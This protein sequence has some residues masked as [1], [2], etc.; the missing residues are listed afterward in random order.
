MDINFSEE[1]IFDVVIIG[2]GPSGSTAAYYLATA[3]LKVL[4]V[5]KEKFPRYKTCGGGV[6][7]R[8]AGYLD[9]GLSNVIEKCINSA[10]VYENANNQ[11]FTVKKDFPII[12][13]VMREKFD[14]YLVKEAVKKNARFISGVEVINLIEKNNVVEIQA[15]G[16]TVK[17]KFVICADGA[18]GI[19]SRIIKKNKKLKKIPALEWE[20][21]VSD[22]LYNKFSDYA[23]FDF[24]FIDEGYVWIFPKKYHLSVGVAAVGKID[25]KLSAVLEKYLSEIGIT[26]I[27]HI[28]KH[29]YII[30]L[31]SSIKKIVNNRIL[32][33]GDALG[34]ADPIV[35]EGISYAIL[36][37]KLAA[38]AII[39]GKL[40]PK[41]VIKIY[42][43]NLAKKI[44]RELKFAEFCSI[45]VYRYPSIR[46]LLF[47]KYGDKLVNFMTGII[48]ENAKYSSLFL[49]PLSYLKLIRY[50]FRSVQRSEEN[51]REVNSDV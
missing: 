1:Q 48:T 31:S 22:D 46:K 25:F 7:S 38:D 26:G 9:F 40:E 32:L 35:F 39:T 23:R 15:N 33:V 44:F 24:G 11:K 49:N 14:D 10:V 30:P 20:I 3:G 12:N 6:V 21:R 29:G 19:S 8:A 5:E 27:N 43:K 16:N 28:E 41:D 36:S 17:S 18:N 4:I 13:M 2:A 37:G 47:K 45:L 42:K 34:V 51:E 50:Y